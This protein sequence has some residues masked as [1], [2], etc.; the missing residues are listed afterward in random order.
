M[1]IPHPLVTTGLCLL[2]TLLPI[3]SSLAAPA[4]P[5]APGSTLLFLGGEAVRQELQLTPAQAKKLDALRADYRSKARRLT[6]GVDPTKP[7]PKILGRLQTLTGDYDAKALDVLTPNQAANLAA[8]QHRTLGAWM[9]TLP[10]VQDTLGLSAAQRGQV[11]HVLEK[12]DA[13]VDE[14][15]RRAFAGEITQARR[16]DQLKAA[17]QQETRSLERILTRTQRRQ[18]E[19][20][21]QPASVMSEGCSA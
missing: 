12:F 3:A 4:A 9:I 5:E 18:L 8:L 20:L 7:S 19:G 10:S 2:L 6:A 16:L 1:R 13:T 17:R 11:G 21:G 14:L 15:N